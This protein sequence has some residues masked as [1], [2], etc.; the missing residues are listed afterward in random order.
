MELSIDTSTEQA[1]LAVSEAG[2]PV[3]ELSWHAGQEQT[4]QLL[5]SLES[6]LR[7]AKASMN[8][9]RAV[10]VAIGPGTFNGLR[11]ALS[12]AKGIAFARQV[13]LVGVSTMEVEAYPFLLGGSVVCPVHRAGREEVA[14]ACFRQASGEL[15]RVV[16]EHITTIDE[17]CRQTTTGTVVCGEM[18]PDL[19][20]QLRE[21]LGEAAVIPDV[22]L[23]MRRAGH[24]ATIGWRR[25]AR[26]ESDDISTLQP[27]YLRRPH[28][29]IPKA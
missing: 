4:S 3:A 19:I 5:P 1:G 14:W 23:R 21:R 26:G 20:E 12:T 24:L 15:Q 10:F 9:V 17:L 6:L 27:L 13:P 16:E 11:V 28:I 18:G 2:V 29:T 22:S 7:Q 25:L 8:D